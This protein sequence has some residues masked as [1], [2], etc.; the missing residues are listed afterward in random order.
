MLCKFIALCLKL[1]YVTLYVEHIDSTTNN[2]DIYEDID[3]DD[4]GDIESDGD[5]KKI[6]LVKQNLLVLPKKICISIAAY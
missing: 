5:D 3:N 4:N 2:N 1:P 6:A